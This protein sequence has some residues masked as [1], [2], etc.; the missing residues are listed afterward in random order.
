[1]EQ[2]TIDFLPAGATAV[3]HASQFDAGRVI[4]M[5]LKNGG[6][7]YT[8]SGSEIIKAKITRPDGTSIEENI[9]NTASSYV[10]LVT[11]AG[12]CDVSGTNKG[13]LVIEKDG[14]TIGSK[15]FRMEVEEDAYGGAG[16]VV[17]ES[18]SGAIAS[19]ETDI[20]DELVELKAKIEPVQDLHGYSH[21]WAGGAGKNKINIHGTVYSATKNPGDVIP[22][23]PG[24]VIDE[25]STNGYIREQYVSFVTEGEKVKIT[26]TNNAYGIGFVFSCSPNTRY[27]VSRLSG[28]R[29]SVVFYTIEGIRMTTGYTGWKTGNFSFTSPD[30]DTVGF[31]ILIASPSETNT[32]IIY[33]QIQLEEGSS[34]TEYEP[35]ENICPIS[36]HDEVNITRTG[37]NQFNK[38]NFQNLV[39]KYEPYDGETVTVTFGQTVYKGYLD[40][41]KQ[42]I[43]ATH[44]GLVLST[45]NANIINRVNA[46]KYRVFNTNCGAKITGTD[47]ADIICDKLKSQT[48]STNDG[49]CYI[50]AGG[51]IRMNFATEYNS[52]A[53]MLADT[54][55]IALVYPL[56]T[57]IEIPLS[58]IRQLETR[59]GENNVYNDTG[60]TSLKY[61]KRAG[62]ATA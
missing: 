60:D 59:S 58:G 22:L 52:V 13:E 46:N 49:R 61:Y 41:K 8:L 44:T 31:G 3:C 30:D 11:S 7:V 33:E 36:G 28:S 6:A 37:K 45:D 9:E 39:T 29:M 24:Q 42:K 15:N 20:E 4:R 62:R 25:L 55:S 16:G 23:E 21:P 43:I 26:S 1:M 56:E 2:I 54:G 32:E 14:A 17:V 50:N 34:A 51:D 5:N 47:Y 53:D 12:T 57:P 40:A 19:F 10:D 48:G 18:A 35:Y 38:T 27:T